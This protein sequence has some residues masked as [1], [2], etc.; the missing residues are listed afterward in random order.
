[1]A[2]EVVPIA[3]RLHHI[4]PPMRYGG[5]VLVLVRRRRRRRRRIRT[6]LRPAPGAVA[7]RGHVR[8]VGRAADLEG[9]VVHVAHGLSRVG[10]GL[11]KSFRRKRRRWS[12]GVSRGRLSR[13]VSGSRAATAPQQPSKQ[14]MQYR[15]S[16]EPLEMISFVSWFCNKGGIIRS[17]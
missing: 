16:D 17:S 9:V 4:V 10:V 15:E 1:M 12:S 8:P 14:V 5:T 6:A 2:I 13:S 3:A 11:F 7:G